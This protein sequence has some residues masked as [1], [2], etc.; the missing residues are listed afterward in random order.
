MII[1]KVRTQEEQEAH[2]KWV[3][4]MRGPYPADREQN[5]QALA[6]L[7]AGNMERGSDSESKNDTDGTGLPAVTSSVLF[8]NRVFSLEPC[9]SELVMRGYDKDER[10]DPKLSEKEVLA[11][12]QYLQYW[13]NDNL[14]NLPRWNVQTKEWEGDYPQEKP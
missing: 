5:V 7:V 8:A 3:L 2:E 12:I 14:V 9:G 10:G 1:A 4:E 6:P 11:V 13:V